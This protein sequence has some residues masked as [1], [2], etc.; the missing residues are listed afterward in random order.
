MFCEYGRV[1]A[2][3]ALHSA[4]RAGVVALVAA[5]V[6]TG[7]DTGDGDRS[8]TFEGDL[9]APADPP[10]IPATDSAA[11]PDA[12]TLL[13]HVG[14]IDEEWLGSA[15]QAA[16]I[17][18]QAFEAYTGAELFAQQSL[19]ECELRWNTMAGIGNVESVHGTIDGNALRAD[20]TTE[21]PIIGV[22]LDGSEGVAH[23]PDTDGGAVDGDD[24]YDRAVGPLQ[25]LPGTWQAMGRDGT[26]D[27]VAD[28]HNIY[29]AAAAAIVHLCREDRDMSTDREWVEAILD[30]NQSRAYA[31]D[32]HASADRYAAL[33]AEAVT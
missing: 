11:Q 9:A 18:R 7:C 1:R 32:V 3:S 25:F 6:L 26:G 12:E 22:A 15:A 10:P 13:D 29:D 24:T 2:V 30:Y 28:P 20:G 17:P 21:E 14:R 23:I 8:R 19:P 31:R 16:A 27:G 5:V 33:V 4:A